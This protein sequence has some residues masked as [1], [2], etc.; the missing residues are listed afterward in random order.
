MS[1]PIRFHLDEHVDPDLA[2]ALRRVGIDV[3]TTIE[4]GLR[5][6]SDDR[7]LQFALDESRVLITH[8]QDFLRL[9]AQGGAHCGIAFCAQGTRTM[10]Q[11]IEALILICGV[12]TQDEMLNL[13]EFL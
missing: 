7:Q 4:A 5:T 3:T 2:R 10:R 8:D 11:M 13:V 1:Q 9:A 12:Y 6:S